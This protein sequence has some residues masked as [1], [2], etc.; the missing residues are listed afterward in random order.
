LNNRDEYIY[1]S[2]TEKL[3]D[4]LIGNCQIDFSVDKCIC[5]ECDVFF[6]CKRRHG[7]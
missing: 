7:L 6:E 4:M 1:C 5:K 3:I 2:D